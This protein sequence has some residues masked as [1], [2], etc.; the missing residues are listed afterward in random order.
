MTRRLR[1][2]RSLAKRL[3]QL[4]R[5]ETGFYHPQFP[6]KQGTATKEE[7]VALR[8]LTSDLCSEENE[9]KV[10]ILLHSLCGTPKET[11]GRWSEFK[12]KPR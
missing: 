3:R 2:K 10:P 9:G 12:F 7:I 4:H 8:E 6:V 1:N 5:D 11:A